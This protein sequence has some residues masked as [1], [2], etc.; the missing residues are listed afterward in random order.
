MSHDVDFDVAAANSWK[1]EVEMELDKV[2]QVLDEVAEQCTTIPG[3]QDTIMKGIEETGRI[4]QEQWGNLCG[5]FQQMCSKLGDLIKGRQASIE[6]VADSI[7]S[8]KSNFHL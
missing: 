8:Y 4:M 5:G 6:K 3:E 7:D 1:I 2:R